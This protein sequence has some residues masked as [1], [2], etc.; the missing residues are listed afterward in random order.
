MPSRSRIGGM[1]GLLEG[2]FAGGLDEAWNYQQ[3][4]ADV[5]AE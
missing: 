5:W 1:Q 2:G 3:A 4:N